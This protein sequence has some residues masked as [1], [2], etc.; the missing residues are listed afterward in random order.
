MKKIK[1]TQD[2]YALVDDEDFESLSKWK[3]RFGHG[4]ARRDIKIGG[5]R[6]IYM[7]RQIIG[8]KKGMCTD[9]KDHNGLNNQRNNLRLCTVSQNMCNRRHLKRKKFTIFRGVRMDRRTLKWNAVIS[10][11]GVT[12]YIGSF[13][14]DIE[15]AMAYN[16]YAKKIHGEFC[17]LNKIK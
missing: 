12:R 11:D 9:H 6:T 17:I 3:W 7:H 15:A 1:L 13:K 14:S 16:K 10:K 5:R 4:Y 8:A 2:K